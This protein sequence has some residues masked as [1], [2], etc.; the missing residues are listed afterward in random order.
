MSVDNSRPI[1]ESYWHSSWN[2]ES[3][4]PGCPGCQWDVKYNAGKRG[5]TGQKVET[6]A[7]NNH[8]WIIRDD[9]QS[10][11]VRDPKVPGRFIIQTYAPPS[12]PI[13]G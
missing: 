9:G 7:Q 11:I 6:M 13:M 10:N 8:G 4:L 2:D 5:Y 12:L 1:C 3:G